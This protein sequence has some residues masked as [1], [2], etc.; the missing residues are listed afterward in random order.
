MKK[1]LIVVLMTVFLTGCYD[2]TYTPPT[3]TPGTV[4]DKQSA[5]NEAN[6]QAIIS[7]RDIPSLSRSQDYDNV[8]D[9][10]EYLNDGNTVGYLYLVDMGQIILEVPV[11]GK[12]TSLNTYITP[13][14]DIQKIEEG[15]IRYETGAYP[16]TYAIVQA[17]DLDGTYGENV[18]GVFWFTADGQY[19]EWNGKYLFSAHRLSFQS[20]PI[21]IE[22]K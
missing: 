12:V 16:G 6:A 5:A 9:R 4:F 22:S 18:D 3:P 19:M 21:L 17:P 7:G 8:I 20:A 15:Y 2:S 13:M 11:K 14:E 10:A 1:I